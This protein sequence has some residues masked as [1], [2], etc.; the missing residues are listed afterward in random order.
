MILEWNNL[1]TIT[2]VNWGNYYLRKENESSFYIYK[3]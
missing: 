2:K 1:L 3:L